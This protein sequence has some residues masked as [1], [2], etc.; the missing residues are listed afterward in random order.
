MKIFLAVLLL[1]SSAWARVCNLDEIRQ[2]DIDHMGKRLSAYPQM[3]QLAL[4]SPIISY[5]PQYD[6]PEDPAYWTSTFVGALGGLYFA[7]KN[8][9]AIECDDEQV[10]TR[11]RYKPTGQELLNYH[12][13]QR[14]VFWETYTWTAIWLGSIL[15]TTHYS[16]K[17]T[18]A[19]FAL[20]LPWSYSFSRPWTPWT[21]DFQYV[22][23]CDQQGV[24]T[25]AVRFSF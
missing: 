1:A 20:I 5:V 12:E 18:A 10:S 11:G 8:R 14:G 3:T 9:H 6:Q 7:M 23:Y 15:M 22:F 4:W 21:E 19:I 24:N 2:I 13:Q 16:E 25:A 17:K